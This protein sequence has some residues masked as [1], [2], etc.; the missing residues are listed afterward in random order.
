[1]PVFYYLIRVLI[2][3]TSRVLFRSV[4]LH[5]ER[6]PKKGGYLICMNHSSYIDPLHI[7]A[8]QT[9]PVHYLAKIELFK[10]WFLRWFF[11]SML[12]VPVDRKKRDNK[13]AWARAIETLKGGG[14]IGIFPEGTTKHVGQRELMKGHT[15][16]ARLALLA[17]VPVVPA[18]IANN[19]DILRRHESVR[20]L[21]KQYF[22]VGQP[23][24]FREYYG[25]DEDK[26]VLR[27]LTDKIMGRV[28]EL[29]VE[30][31]RYMKRH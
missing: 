17:H 14:I 4:I 20:G 13:E 30:G 1:M 22:V 28:E 19:T 12:Q 23:M 26:E 5:R 27:M 8:Y 29:I 9:R 15:G 11:T 24:Y 31:E 7:M 16:V 25:Q 10:H 3:F 6:L 2:I 18:G 21:R